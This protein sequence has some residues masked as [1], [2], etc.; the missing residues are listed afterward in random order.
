MM[1]VSETM[2]A[3]KS[4][5]TV[6]TSESLLTRCCALRLAIVGESRPIPGCDSSRSLRA[7]VNVGATSSS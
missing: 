5:R 1:S 2:A 3:L 6:M 4:F 7:L